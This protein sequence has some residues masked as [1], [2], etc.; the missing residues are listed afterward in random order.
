MQW[1]AEKKKDLQI[2]IVGYQVVTLETEDLVYL[3][4][5]EMLVEYLSE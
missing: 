5:F 3:I 4:L 2:I 1:L